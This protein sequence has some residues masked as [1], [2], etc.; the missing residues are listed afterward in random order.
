MYLKKGANISKSLII[1]GKVI[2]ALA[3]LHSQKQ[4]LDFIPYRDS[5]YLAAQEEVG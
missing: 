2:S 1:L 5:A 3:D 4:K